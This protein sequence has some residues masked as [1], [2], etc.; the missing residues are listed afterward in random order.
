MTKHFHPPISRGG[1]LKTNTTTL[2]SKVTYG[3]RG[4]IKGCIATNIAT[5]AAAND[6]T[7]TAN[8]AALDFVSTVL[9]QPIPEAFP[10]HELPR[11]L[12]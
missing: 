3:T 1:W 9:R 2:L 12:L 10:T 11:A 5:T 6:A 8:A 7:I 4:H